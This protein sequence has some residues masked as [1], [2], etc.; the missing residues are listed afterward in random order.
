MLVVCGTGGGDASGQ[1][2]GGMVEK[3]GVIEFEFGQWNLFIQEGRS[4]NF[5]ELSNLVRILE[6]RIGQ[7]GNHQGTINGFELFIFTDNLVAENAYYKG[8]STS[9]LLFELILR[10][11]VLEMREQIILHV[12]HIAGTRM[13]ACGIDG[14][15]RGVTLEG[16]MKG[17]SLIYFVPLNKSV[18][19][20]SHDFKDWISQWWPE[21]F[22]LRFLEYK[23][24]FSALSDVKHGYVWVPPPAV[25]DMAVELMTKAIHKRPYTT[26]IFVCPRLLTSKWRKQLG[27]ATD[28]LWTIPLTSPVWNKSQHE[29]LMF[30]IYFPLSIRYPW[31]HKG[32]I[33]VDGVARQ[34]SE[35][36]EGD[37]GSSGALL[38]K[39]CTS[40][41]R[42]QAMPRCV[43]P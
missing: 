40:A 20:R 3:E 30:A 27:K 21:G 15:S 16:V 31:R 13:Q 36:W 32:V 43:V 6:E 28:L 41:W 2:F 18:L 12:I 25:A 22:G 4:S 19:D 38:R 42:I 17:R 33:T 34:L 24:W 7:G 10:L 35:L 8:N 9:P 5:K 1:G 23:D 26:H 11:R 37:P 14:L 29:P 39:L